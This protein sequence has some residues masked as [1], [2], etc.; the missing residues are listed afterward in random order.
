MGS[1]D[2][3]DRIRPYFI[4]YM[5]FWTIQTIA[6][7]V[8][9]LPFLHLNSSANTSSFGS[10]WQDAT[11]AAISV[12][13]LLLETIADYQKFKFKQQK[14]KEFMCTGVWS[15]VRYPNYSGEIAFWIGIYISASVSN[16][17]M[18][19]YIVNLISPLFITWL[20]TR[21]SGIPLLEKKQAQNY[22]DRADFKDYTL[23][24]A[25]LIPFVY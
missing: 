19:D 12:F 18:L 6:I 2:R 4:K 10:S 17:T 14:P 24:T 8:I 11:G 7:I 16:V 13:G 25:K 5:G 15:I 21:L 9:S 1:D 23:K 22:G 20:L 3:F